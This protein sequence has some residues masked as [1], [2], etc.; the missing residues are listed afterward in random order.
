MILL[1]L[2]DY[3]HNE[4]GEKLACFAIDFRHY[5]SDQCCE[6]DQNVLAII[7]IVTVILMARIVNKL[8]IFAILEIDDENGD[9]PPPTKMLNSCKYRLSPQYL[10]N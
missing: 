4:N 5:F 2:L 1:A 8:F 6:N 10:C 9:A 7:A 3:C